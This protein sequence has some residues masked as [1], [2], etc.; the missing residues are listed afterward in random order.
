M[1]SREVLRRIRQLGGRPVRL[2]QVGSHA[3][4]AVAGCRTI[5][6]LHADDLPVGTLR[7]IERD[8]E[9]CLGRRWLRP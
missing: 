1:T 5:I 4:Y 8:L 9:P 3:K 2:N 6:P 7:A